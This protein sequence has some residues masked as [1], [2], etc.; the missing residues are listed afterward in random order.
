M[1][2]RN[3]GTSVIL[4]QE[5]AMQY[6]AYLADNHGEYLVETMREWDGDIAA[7][8]SAHA[9]VEDRPE[10]CNYGAAERYITIDFNDT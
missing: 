4:T 10:I 3:R 8:I 7:S 9:E 6:I 5:D 1:K 2:I